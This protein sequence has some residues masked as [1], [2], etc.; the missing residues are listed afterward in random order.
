MH[1]STIDKSHV[2]F[3]GTNGIN[4]ISDDC[5]K[6]IRALNSGKKINEFMFHPT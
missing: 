6:E 5:G 4:W 1:Q 3:L 2:V